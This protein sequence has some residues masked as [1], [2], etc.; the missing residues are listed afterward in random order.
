VQVWILGSSG[1]ESAA[2]AGRHGLAFAA[3]YHVQPGNVL[4]AIAAYRAAF[5][6]STHR[7]RPR[8]AVSADVV[9]ADSDAAAQRLAAGYGAWVRSIRTGAGAIR[10]PSA[11]PAPTSW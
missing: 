2:V 11:S 7:D 8:V 5:E 4:D 3:N 6:P 10:F 9:V 1:G